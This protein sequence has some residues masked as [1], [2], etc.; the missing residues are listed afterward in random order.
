MPKSLVSES[1]KSDISADSGQPGRGGG[2]ILAV[3]S[4]VA[5]LRLWVT[6][7]VGLA[8]D[9]A[10]KAWAVGVLGAPIDGYHRD[11]MV[12]IEDYLSLRTVFNRGAVAGSFEGKT[13]FLLAASLV[14]IALLLWLFASS[15]SNQGA[16][17][18]GVGMVLAG[19][20]GNLHDRLFNNGQVVDFIEVNLH[21]WPANPWPTFNV[22]DALLCVGVGILVVHLFATRRGKPTEQG[23]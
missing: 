6:A 7:A 19:A 21:F 1:G 4:P 23:S 22:A 5:H 2:R 11:A 3:R 15:R 10:S 13:G 14:A 8:A 12:V 20:L 9:L 16:C 17:H 18:I